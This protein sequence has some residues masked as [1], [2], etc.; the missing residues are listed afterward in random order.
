MNKKIKTILAAGL[1]TLGMAA[2][3]CTLAAWDDGANVTA[4]GPEEGGALNYTR[5]SGLCS[6]KS[7]GTNAGRVINDGDGVGVLDTSGPSQEGTMITRFYFLAEGTGSG[8]IFQAFSDDAETTPVYTVTFDG[9]DVTVTPNDGGTDT[10]VGSVNAAY[11]WHS[12]EIEWN[13]GGAINLWVDTHSITDAAAANAGVSGNAATEI[14]SVALGGAND[15]TSVIFDEYESRRSS[16]IGRLQVGNVDGD[17]SVTGA[18]VI[19]ILREASFILVNDQGV[20]DV[21][22]S[23]SIDGVDVILALRIASFILDIPN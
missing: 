12:V 16:P 18:D 10:A 20:P 1:L 7:D 5:Y 14:E 21:D 4:G 22:K 8:I 3:A 19:L 6:M 9:T 11:N 15:F 17:A 23:G 13:Q 2:Q